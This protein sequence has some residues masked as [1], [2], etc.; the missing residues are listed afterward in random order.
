MQ[1]I[2][3]F[4][5]LFRSVFLSNSDISSIFLNLH[6]QKRLGY[7]GDGHAWNWLNH[8]RQKPYK[9]ETCARRVKAEVDNPYRDLNYSAY[10]KNR[11]Q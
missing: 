5:R 8:K 9:R 6:M 3:V 11:I 2:F 1:Y 4:L 10:H 7:G